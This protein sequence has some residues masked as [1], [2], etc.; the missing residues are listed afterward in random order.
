MII[1]SKLPL[2]GETIFTTMSALAEKHKAINLAQGFPD[3]A[4]DQRL[5]SLLEEYATQAVHQ[6]APMAGLLR[7]REQVSQ[8]L[9]THTGCEYTPGEEITITAGATQAL[10][11]AIQAFVAAGDEVIYFEPAY[12]S[13]QPAI[14]LAGG[15]GKPLP[16]SLPEG[17]L[18][19]ELLEA[20]VSPATK[21]IIL[22]AP[23]NPCGTL[24]AEDDM[25]WLRDFVVKHDLLLLSDEVYAHL[26]FPGE[27]FYSAAS[28]PELAKR[29]LVVGSFGKTFHCTGWKVGYIAAPAELM[30]EFRKVHQYNVFCVNRP[31]QEVLAD[32]LSEPA[33]LAEPPALFDARYRFFVDACRETGFSFA[34]AF[35]TYFVLA[36]FSKLAEEND[37]EFCIRLVEEAGVAAIPLSSFY[38]HSETAPAGWIRFC[39]AKKEET[40]KAA[41]ERLL[42]W[43]RKQDCSSI[44]PDEKNPYF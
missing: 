3:F 27:K 29:S 30:Q 13:Y 34:P 17:A 44:M 15:V 9:N 2:V 12:D 41:S 32:M 1:R 4:P 26:V 6:Y 11:T 8:V 39:F 24:L 25:R 31:A 16:L 10:F 42:N 18:P 19:K 36:D 43:C 21:M 22:N 28:F 33:H 37:K 14:T 5:T 20:T 40:L 7:L 38:T 35:G 23:H